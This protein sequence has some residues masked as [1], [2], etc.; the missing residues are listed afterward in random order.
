MIFLIYG[1][2][3]ERYLCEL[4][5]DPSDYELSLMDYLLEAG[6]PVA[7]SC[8][9]AGICQKCKVFINNDPL[10]SCELK[11]KDFADKEEITLEFSYL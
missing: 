5:P 9:G 11:I 2:A 1:Q 4:K 3:S 6:I 7:S 10:L 8:S